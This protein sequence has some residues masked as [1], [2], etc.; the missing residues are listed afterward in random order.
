MGRLR[1]E[2]YE[3][4]DADDLEEIDE[5]EYDDEDDDEDDED[6]VEDLD[7]ED[8]DVFDAL[9]YAYTSQV[10]TPA[11]ILLDIKTYLKR[12]HPDIKLVRKKEYF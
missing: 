8:D 3:F 1:I 6:L 11:E 4:L 10:Q 5:E 12:Y 2:D 9:E 7:D